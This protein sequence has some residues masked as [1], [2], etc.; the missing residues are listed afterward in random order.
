MILRIFEKFFKER[1]EGIKVVCSE[2][3]NFAKLEKFS[4]SKRLL[5]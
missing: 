1:E 3:T 5:L 4:E 2:K